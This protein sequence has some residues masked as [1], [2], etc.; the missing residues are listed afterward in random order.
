MSDFWNKVSKCEHKNLSPNYHE[1][2]SCSTPHCS[3]IEEHCLDCG[4]YITKCDCGFC[5][6]F[7]GWPYKRRRGLKIKTVIHTIKMRKEVK[8]G[9]DK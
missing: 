3:G 9:T 6:G 5:N 8:E 1:F 4:V 7:Y 2:V